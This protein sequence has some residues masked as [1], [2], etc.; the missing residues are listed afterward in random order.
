MG[1]WCGHEGYSSL[2]RSK[3]W[4]RQA[5]G[6]KKEMV[7][8]N[9]KEAHMA[10]CGFIQTVTEGRVQGTCKGDFFHM[11]LARASWDPTGFMG[12]QGFV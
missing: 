10:T 9:R 2:A 7:Y 3:G 8:R 4:E 12:P 1:C 6:E 5:K 11:F